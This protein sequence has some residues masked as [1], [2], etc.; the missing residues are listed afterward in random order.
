MSV[1]IV[2]PVYK[3]GP[4]LVDIVNGIATLLSAPIVVI[5]DGS[6]LEFEPAFERLAAFPAVS[7]LRHAVNL[8]K[9][10]ALKTG[11]NYVLVHYPGFATVTVDGDGQH[12]PEDVA[13]I[14][15]R[16]E[17]QPEAL[18][19]G[20]RTLHGPIPWRSR[21]GNAL[22]RVFVRLLVGQ[23]LIDTQTGLRAIPCSLQKSILSIPSQRYEF[24]TEMLIA[25]H[26]LG[27]QILEEPIQTIYE[28]GNSSSHFNPLADSMRIYFVLFRFSVLS[29]ATALIDN[30]VFLFVFSTT[31]N[32]AVSQ[33]MSR[34][35]AVCFNY[36][37]ARRIVF[38]SRE[39][40]R[41]LLPRYLALVAASG[42]ASY[43]LIRM[44]VSSWHTPAPI[45]K[46]AAESLIFLANFAVQRDFVFRRR[47][48]QASTDWDAYYKRTL[49]TARLTRL[50]TTRMILEAL[51]RFNATPCPV[52][53]EIG[54]ANSCFLD[55]IVRSVHP[56]EYHVIDTNRLGLSLLQ[57]RI[58]GNTP[59]H[60]HHSSVHDEAIHVSADVV[61]SVGLIEHFDSGGTER[62]IEG[63]LRLLKPGG[64]LILT[65]PTPTALYRSTRFLAELLGTWRFPDERPILPWEVRPQLTA[66]GKVVFE[67]TLWPLILTQ[68]MIVAVKNQHAPEGH[69]TSQAANSR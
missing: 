39:P 44:F 34:A 13:R 25:A 50:Y 40:D 30:L 46:V 37:A 35:V 19:L 49:W 32:I 41:I 52:I 1:A 51:H 22:T 18:V 9:G 29:M 10:A 11:M 59:I 43:A 48:E 64:T 60:L 24:E 36:G 5:D 54:G 66:H 20:S 63:H 68:H 3:P 56:S 27:C 47:M 4:A 28:P 53:A 33:V 55:A 67:K 7:V 17:E 8:G 15:E 62:A 65:Y 58:D 45:A 6:G 31:R 2:I 12:A 69:L 16:H 26:H 61:F 21:L 38:L 14:V 23:R 57:S 42:V